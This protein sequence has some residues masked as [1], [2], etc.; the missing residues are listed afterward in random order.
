VQNWF[1]VRRDGHLRSLCGRYSSIFVLD[2]RFGSIADTC[3][4]TGTYKN[5]TGDRLCDT[6]PAGSSTTSTGS[7]AES[8]CTCNAG[9]TGKDGKECAKCD[10]GKFKT[11]RGVSFFPFVASNFILLSLIPLKSS[12]ND[13]V[14]ILT[15]DMEQVPKCA[16][17]VLATAG[18]RAG[19]TP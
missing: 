11:E 9:W 13:E 7:E 16:R 18:R 15:G 19:A 17:S 12:Q 14:H 5:A 8:S 10:S 3:Q 2:L 1:R 4:T 6:C